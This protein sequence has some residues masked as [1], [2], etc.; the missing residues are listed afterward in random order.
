MG[1]TPAGSEA[2]PALKS[3]RH[4]R[5]SGHEGR[6]GCGLQESSSQD[7]LRER[8]KGG[9]LEGVSQ[10]PAPCRVDLGTGH[11]SAVPRA[12][13]CGWRPPPVPVAGLPLPLFW[14]SMQSRRK[15]SFF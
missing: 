2:K 3:A 8:S 5:V 11:R 15:H 7:L 4:N 9:R 1:D 6:G 13:A 14:A 12:G 10:G